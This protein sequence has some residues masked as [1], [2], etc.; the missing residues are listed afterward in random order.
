MISVHTYEGF[1][2]HKYYIVSSSKTKMQN[3]TIELHDGRKLGYRI[4]GPA[5]VTEAHQ[6]I[7][8]FVGTP[9]TRNYVTATQIEQLEKYRNICF[10]ALERPGF[11]LSTTLYR[12]SI[13]DY[14][15]DVAEFA[16]KMNI[17]KCSIIGYSGGGPFALACAYKLPDLITSIIYLQ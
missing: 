10:I 1:R 3:E 16:E 2:V 12:R 13:I 17:T 7:L 6:I 15:K 9:G 5:T 11:G 8:Y 14:P 4:F